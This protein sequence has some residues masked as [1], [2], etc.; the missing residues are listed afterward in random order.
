VEPS[1]VPSVVPSA[2]PSVEPSAVPSVVPS[3]VPSVEPSKSP[4]LFPTRF[5]SLAPVRLST[6]TDFPTIAPSIQTQAELH[7]GVAFT[8][9]NVTSEVL[10]QA[11]IDTYLI[12]VATVANV[13]ISQV[14]YLGYQVVDI[15]PITTRRMLSQNVMY[16]LQ[17]NSSIVYPMV[18]HPEYKGNTTIAYKSMFQSFSN[19]IASQSIMTILRQAAIENV[20]YEFLN[21]GV[22]SVVP[23]APPAVI[24]PT[25]VTSS[26]TNQG[27][28][29]SD[30]E[31]VGIVLGVF[32]GCLLIVMGCFFFNRCMVAKQRK[33]DEPLQPSNMND[34]M[35]ADLA[36]GDDV[37]HGK[38]QQQ[39][40]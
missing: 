36:D 37:E 1:A 32:F 35:I 28:N 20:A 15:V 23:A 21:S 12:T 19:L 33:S 18:D 8:I 27:D 26:D 39:Q 40:L 34:A 10:T 7:F 38:Q 5:P 13:S 11:A 31:I 2:V 22:S 30:G 3:A 17:M 4:S 25:P 24:Q 29:V 16:T 14:T 6:A 9:T